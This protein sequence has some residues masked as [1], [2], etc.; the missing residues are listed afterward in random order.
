MAQFMP[1]TFC[2]S[3]AVVHT[4]MVE[5]HVTTEAAR[6][7]KVQGVG[8]TLMTGVMNSIKKPG[9]SMREG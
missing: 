1:Q 6:M 5:E 9:R 8:T 3:H 2:H 4:R 7:Q